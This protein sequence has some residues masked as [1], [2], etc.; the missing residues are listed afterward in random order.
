MAKLVLTLNEK[1][2]GEYALSGD[3]TSIGRRS[4]NT[5]QIQSRA[6][7]GRH[8]RVIPVLNEYIIEDLNSTNGTYINGQLIQKHTLSNGDKIAVGRHELI[9]IAENEAELERT[10]QDSSIIDSALRAANIESTYTR[11]REK[12]VN[13]SSGKRKLQVANLLV[14]SGAKQGQKLP[15]DKPVITIGRPGVAIAAITRRSEGYFVLNV[16]NN[17]E[18]GPARLNGTEL[19]H[20]P[21]KLVAGDDLQIAGINIEFQLE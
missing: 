10:A 7:S 19:S 6:V 3:S 1:T 8:A 18:S 21:L 14:K 4:N 5:V 2:L 15:V 17:E 20:Q 11:S 9:F 12:V 16:D 13:I